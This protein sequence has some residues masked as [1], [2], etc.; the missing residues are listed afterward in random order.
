MS[1]IEKIYF[2]SSNVHKKAEMQRLI[3]KGIEIVLPCDENIAFQ[4]EENGASFIANAIIKAETLYRQVHAPVLAD[5][6]GLVVR[7][8]DGRPGIH[9]ARY[10]CTE[11]R[12]LTS[13]EQYTLLLEEMKTKEDRSAV[14]V[15]A[16]VLMLSAERIFIV[17]ETVE[18]KIATAPAG[19]NGFGYDPVFIVADTGKSASEL[20]ADEKDRLSHRG[21]AMRKINELI[22]MEEGK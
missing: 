14:F 6:S 9:T 3:R 7:A 19:V 22:A 4:A 20:S 18:G 1:Q 16:C 12:K 8:L 11:E 15:C 21:R 17:Q 2:A 5:D 13:Q 10:G